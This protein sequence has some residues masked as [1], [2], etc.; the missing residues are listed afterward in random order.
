[1]PE[2]GEIRKSG[3]LGYKRKHNKYTWHACVDC[4]KERWSRLI[5]GEPQSKR[6]EACAR[7]ITGRRQRGDKS[8]FWKGGRAKTGEGYILI[9]LYPDDFF[10]PMH[11]YNNYV[12]EHRL[13]IA[14]SLG[15]C[16]QR[17]E[18]VHH[19]N[20]I[21]DDNRIENLQLV[22]DDRHKQITLMETRISY[23][24]AKLDEILLGQKDLKQE[25]RLLRLQNK[26]LQE[27]NA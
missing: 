26:M 16:L 18:I 24:T 22:S 1:M 27:Q 10:Y 11:N 2:L 6:C 19:K 8:S 21:K 7:K 4:G 5:R 17:W 15:R 9:Y 14:K 3:E 12:M 23:L 25:I 13:V 20:H